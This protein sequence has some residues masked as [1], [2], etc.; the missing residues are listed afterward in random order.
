MRKS[1]MLILP[2]VAGLVVLAEP[3]I[4]FLFEYGAWTS[5]STVAVARAIQIQALVLPAMLVS[6]IYS[7]TLYASQDVKT[8]VRTSMISLA[9]ATVLYIG[10]FPFIGYLAIPVGVVVSGY[11]KNALLAHACRKRSLISYDVRTRRTMLAFALWAAIVGVA[12]TMVPVT[13]IWVL[14]L[15]IAGYGIIYL[16]G[17]YVIDRCL[18]RIK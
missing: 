16:P 17:A 6:Q 5:E 4:R 14:G 15:A 7:K 3:I 1:L 9:L 18:A 13:S 12:L 11:V 2:C 10:L 8:P